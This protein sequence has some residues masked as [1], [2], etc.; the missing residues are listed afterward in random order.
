MITVAASAV[1]T[2]GGPR[3]PSIAATL[4]GSWSRASAKSR[5]AARRG[6]DPDHRG[7]RLAARVTAALEKPPLTCALSFQ[8]LPS[9]VVDRR[10]GTPSDGLSPPD[11]RGPGP[12]HRA[13]WHGQS[14][15]GQDPRMAH[16]LRKSGSP[17]QATV[18]WTSVPGLW[19]SFCRGWARQVPLQGKLSDPENNEVSCTACSLYDAC[20]GRVGFRRWGGNGWV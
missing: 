7:V 12:M 8:R 5:F 2:R 15:T 6:A 16:F 9:S 17:D 4:A 13:I 14:H 3:L 1:R 10:P 11:P 18:L 19:P 20:W